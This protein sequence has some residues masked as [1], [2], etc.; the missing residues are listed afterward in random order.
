MTNATPRL[1]NKGCR[2]MAD[3]KE[4]L[5][6]GIEPVPVKRAHGVN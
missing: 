3:Y 1:R 4:Q 2:L 6:A 5:E